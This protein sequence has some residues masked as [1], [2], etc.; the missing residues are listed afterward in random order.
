MK[1]TSEF[2]KAL[3]TF[4][5]EHGRQLPWRQPEQDG[6]FDAYK[7]LVSEM[8]LQQTQVG[9]VVPKYETFLKEFP[10]I[11]SLA[12]ASL[13]Q[14]LKSWLGLGYNRRA[15]YLWQAAQT[16][17]DKPQPWSFEDLV[18]CK[19]IGPNTAA[20]VIAYA[21]DEPVTFIETNIRTVIIHHFF[22]GRA[23]VTDKEILAVLQSI[24]P[25]LHPVPSTLNPRLFYWAMMDFGTFLKAS[26]GNP[27][28]RSKSYA[29]QSKFEG[30]K[31]Q[32]RGRVL[33][34]L[35]E[36]PEQLK[37]LRAQ[38]TD[39]RLIEVIEELQAEELISVQDKT[40]MLYNGVIHR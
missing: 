29:K 5:E 19:G 11:Q 40:V 15:K 39:E 3:R 1:T 28:K 38:L 12:G 6:G 4:Y 37:D 31:R 26:V 13:E 33:R 27:N 20:A 24:V 18:S 7:I 34:M 17:A 35:A 21:Y 10:D 14:V 25:W 16:L 30:S 22:T 36:S 23:D 32:L 9:R 2:L 8:M